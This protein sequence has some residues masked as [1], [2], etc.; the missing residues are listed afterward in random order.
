MKKYIF[1]S[2]FI[3][4][5]H[6]ALYG[7]DFYPI[8]VK[9]NNSS[10]GIKLGIRSNE[11]NDCDDCGTLTFLTYIPNLK[12]ESGTNKIANQTRNVQI[13]D[14]KEKST[15]IVTI[16]ASNKL[17][18]I[19]ITGPYIIEYP[20]TIDPIKAGARRD[21]IIEYAEESNTSENPGSYFINSIPENAKI[22]IKGEPD[23]FNY[24]PYTIR[25]HAA[26]KYYLTLEKAGFKTMDFAINIEKGIHYDTTFIL[27]EDFNARGNLGSFY[28]NTVPEGARISIK[29]E[30]GFTG[31][32]PY[33]FK[34]RVPGKYYIK[35]EKSNY[36]PVDL[37]IDIEKGKQS[38]LTV[39]LIPEKEINF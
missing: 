3:F 1:I 15:Y 26:G 4:L 35:L 27:K 30:P 5:A 20:L 28:I 31:Q 18:Q 38:D 11:L 36:N 19:K 21:F 17:Q 2:I 34:D 16:Q 37:D 12:F 24:T 9:P 23:F 22:T 14:G 8:Q 29:G 32:T 6:C 10:E 25:D 33:T 13:V 39:K 7:Q